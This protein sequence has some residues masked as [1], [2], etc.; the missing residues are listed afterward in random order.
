[1][2]PRIKQDKLAE[3]SVGQHQS[4]IYLKNVSNFKAS[5]RRRD[6]Q[7]FLKRENKVWNNIDSALNALG[8]FSFTFHAYRKLALINA[9]LRYLLYPSFLLGS[10]ANISSLPSL[11][12]ET[13]KIAE[14]FELFHRQ[15]M[16]NAAHLVRRVE[17]ICFTLIEGNS[18]RSIRSHELCAQ[19]DIIN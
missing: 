17:Q 4:P 16:G 1:M 18:N 2:G 6:S 14:E 12:G 15:V 9:R 3:N 8:P 5:L 13:I 19:S 11:H 10:H 7:R